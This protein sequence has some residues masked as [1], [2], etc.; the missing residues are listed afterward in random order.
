MKITLKSLVILALGK[1]GRVGNVY[2]ECWWKWAK[3]YSRRDLWRQTRIFGSDYRGN[4]SGMTDIII[5][6]L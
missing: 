5:E 4:T 6:I 3:N 2:S 1:I